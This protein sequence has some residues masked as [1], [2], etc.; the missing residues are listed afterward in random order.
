MLKVWPDVF[1][2]SKKDEVEKELKCQGVD[3]RW[4][5]NNSLHIYSKLEAVEKHP[6]TG[7]TVWFNHLMVSDLSGFQW[8]LLVKPVAAYDN[9]VSSFCKFLIA[10]HILQ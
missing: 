9:D 10:G 8:S 6:G 2:T 3:Y 5:K 4:G 7:D 1:Q